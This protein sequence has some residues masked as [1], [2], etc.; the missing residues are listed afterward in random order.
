M[1][2]YDYHC[3]RATVNLLIDK[4]IITEEEYKEEVRRVRFNESQSMK[5]EKYRI[6]YE[7]YCKR[8]DRKKSK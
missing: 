5:E 3:I 6:S 2:S 7:E 1:A 8:L 4:G